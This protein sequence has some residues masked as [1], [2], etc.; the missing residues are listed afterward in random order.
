MQ[1]N[2]EIK[3]LSVNCA[4]R[5]RKFKTPTYKAFEKEMI[6]M[7]PTKKE[8]FS[9]MLRI[10]FYFGFSSPLA[11]IDNPVK[12]TMDILQKKYGFNDK[13][14]FEMNVRKCIVPKGKEFISFQIDNLLPFE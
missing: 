5:G 2:L 9:E 6:L 14:V 3:P 4:Y 13:H 8:T 7:L 10:E 11:D 1:V 12:P